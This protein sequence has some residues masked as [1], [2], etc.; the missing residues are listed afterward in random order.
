[1][2]SCDL[3]TDVALQKVASVHRLHNASLTMLLA[4]TPN[5]EDTSAPGSKKLGESHGSFE[6]HIDVLVG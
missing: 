6:N 1:M 5:L 4:P 2:V 3:I